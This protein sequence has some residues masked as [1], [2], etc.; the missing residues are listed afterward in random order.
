[1]DSADEPRVLTLVAEPVLGLGLA[2]SL[3]KVGQTV[4]EQRNRVSEAL[5]GRVEEA[6][7]AVVVHRIGHPLRGTG[8]VS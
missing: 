1:M 2:L 4:V 7:V 5:H 6:C 3:M 8:C